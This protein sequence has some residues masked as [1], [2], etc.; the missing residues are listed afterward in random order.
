MSEAASDNAGLLAEFAELTGDLAVALQSEAD[1]WVLRVHG[2]DRPEEIEFTYTPP[3]DKTDPREDTN[4]PDAAARAPTAPRTLT[5]NAACTLCA[6]RTF[7]LRRFRRPGRLPVLVLHYS[8]PFR[9]GDSL[10]DRSAELLFGTPEEDGLYDRMLQALELTRDDFHYL[11]YPGC[12]FNPERSLPED[13]NRRCGNCLKHLN[14]T[15]STNGIR[16]LLL[17]GMSAVFLLSEEKARAMALTAE[18]LPVPLDAGELPAL[19]LRSPAAVRALE[20][21]RAGLVSKGRD[22]PD[23]QKAMEEEKRVKQS[24]LD[25]LR[26]ARSR[27]L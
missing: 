27:F 25:A 21:K 12:V 26:A 3:A 9:P 10:R 13:W 2:E 11:Q 17:F 22:D 18:T 8:G 16:L 6:D 4:A 19:V 15:V 23:Y 1:E 14:E 24:M 20:K 7:P 5:A